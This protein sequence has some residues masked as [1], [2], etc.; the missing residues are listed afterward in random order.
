MSTL[1]ADDLKILRGPFPKESTMV[2]VQSYS[3]DKT[4]A[5]LVL[6]LS[7]TDVYERIEQVDPAWS[8]EV[9]K[10]A[11]GKEG[12]SVRMKMT[13]K[14]VSRENVGQGEDEKS[15]Y[16]DALKRAAM[17]FGVGRYLYDSALVWIPFDQNRDKF[18][19]FTMDDYNKALRRDQPGTETEES[20]ALKNAKAAGVAVKPKADSFTQGLNSSPPAK[21]PSPEFDNTPVHTQSVEA[22]TPVLPKSAAQPGSSRDGMN[23]IL[24]QL[25]KPY[26]TKFPETRFPE[27]LMG[28]YNV[29]ETTK[30]TIEQVQDLIRFMESQLG[31]PPTPPPAAAAQKKAEAT[32]AAVKAIGPDMSTRSLLMDAV[33]I[34]GQRL[35]YGLDR[36]NEAVFKKYGTNLDDLSEPHLKTVLANL[37]KE[38]GKVAPRGK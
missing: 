30:M 7:H 23:R 36:I 38:K 21:E 13:I 35:Q 1:I 9:T 8:C 28:R 19:Q 14:G 24:M 27:I 26:L 32:Q 12:V 20:Q 16:S 34:E 4:K 10:E 29:G 3:K 11:A 17:L 31:L 5:M 2:K 18:K 15:A 25:Y 22:K 37:K 33:L 6:Y